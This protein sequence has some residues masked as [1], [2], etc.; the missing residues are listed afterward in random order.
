M[1]SVSVRMKE[2]QSKK[3]NLGGWIR[4]AK[5][6]VLTTVGV[7]PTISRSQLQVNA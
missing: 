1:C 2:S 4:R 7:E 5:D 6:N 3:L